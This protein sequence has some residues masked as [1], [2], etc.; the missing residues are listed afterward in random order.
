M[1]EILAQIAVNYFAKSNRKSIKMAE[2]SLPRKLHGAMKP[3]RR[4]KKAMM[5]IRIKGKKVRAMIA[6]AKMFEGGHLG[7]VVGREN[8]LERGPSEF[9]DKDA[10]HL[11][12]FEQLRPNPSRL[13]QLPII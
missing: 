6:T 10:I 5:P 1:S 12:L 8:C 11:Q 4:G 13:P 9:K 2:V 7:R 3:K